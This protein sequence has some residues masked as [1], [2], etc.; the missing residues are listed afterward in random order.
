MKLLKKIEKK[1]QW[2]QQ[3]NYEGGV[4][5][6]KI[7][8]NHKIFWT[9][10]KEEKGTLKQVNWK[11]HHHCPT[12]K[13]RNSTTDGDHRQMYIHAMTTRGRRGAQWVENV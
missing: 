7:Y 3:G 1:G 11:I 5:K 12:I 9:Y 6:Y 4:Q 2:K 13:R 10:G 8:L